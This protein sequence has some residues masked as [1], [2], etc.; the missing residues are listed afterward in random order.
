MIVYSPAIE[1]AIEALSSLPTIGRKSAQRLVF[2]LLRQPESQVQLLAQALI[3]LKERV[4]YCSVCYTFTEQD[5]CALC[6]SPN[7][8]RDI[9]CVVEQPSDVFAIERT[10]EYRGLYH[11]LHGALDP[12]QG[13]TA[14]QLK[15]APLMERLQRGTFV[16]VILA[17]NPTVEGEV[18][19]HYLAKLIAPLGIRLTRI[20]RGVPVGMDLEFADEATLSRALAGRS[21]V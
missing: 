3:E 7:R 10:G 13:I 20:A 11:V 21:N 17:L 19:T 6:T 5:P 2:H 4:K 15:I 9:L 12:L 1:R 14:E 16:E 8:D 18:T